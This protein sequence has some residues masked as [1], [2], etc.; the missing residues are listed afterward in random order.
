[1]D[2]TFNFIN[3]VNLELPRVKGELFWLIQIVESKGTFLDVQEF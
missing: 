3:I 2:E 1:M